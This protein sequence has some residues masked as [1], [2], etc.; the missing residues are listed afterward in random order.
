MFQQTWNAWNRSPFANLKLSIAPCLVS[1]TACARACIST[2]FSKQTHKYTTYKRHPCNLTNKH[3]ALQIHAS[4]HIDIWVIS[5]PKKSKNTLAP[6]NTH[7]IK[8]RRLIK[9]LLRYCRG[10]TFLKKQSLSKI[11]NGWWNTLLKAKTFMYAENVGKPLQTYQN[12]YK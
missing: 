6:K 1:S 3:R 10:V 7:L 5:S 9:T 8:W 12:Q 2:W 11:W 4:T